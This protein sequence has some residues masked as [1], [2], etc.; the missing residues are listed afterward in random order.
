MRISSRASLCCIA[1]GAWRDTIGPPNNISNRELL[2]PDMSR[3]WRRD[4]FNR[5]EHVLQEAQ[6]EAPSPYFAIEAD[7]SLGRR[8]LM[9]C[10]EPLSERPLSGKESFARSGCML[11]ECMFPSSRT[12]RG[13]A[14]EPGCRDD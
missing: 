6:L 8:V 2:D 14:G 4:G 13:Q 9:K 7:H 11:L 12:S 10:T 1:K 5:L 3:L